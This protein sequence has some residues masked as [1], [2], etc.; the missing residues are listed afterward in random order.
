MVEDTKELIETSG[1]QQIVVNF[2]RQWREQADS[3]LDH[4]WTNCPERTIKIWNEIR[5]YS[6]HNVIGI[7][8]SLKDIKIR[9]NN[10][11]KRCW[12]GFDDKACLQAFK[13]QNWSD[14]KN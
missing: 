12:K 14:I 13:N 2:T 8:I 1:F 6:D 11:L 3:L 7:Q 4:I 9:G 5:G 10:I